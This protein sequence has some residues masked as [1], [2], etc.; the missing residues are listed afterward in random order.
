MSEFITIGEPLVVLCSTQLNKSIADS[1][2]FNRVV[3]GA[4]LNVAIGVSR[5][6]HSAEYISQVGNDPQGEFIQNQINTKKINTQYLRKT[7]KYLTGYQ[8][9]QLVSHGDPKVYNFRKNSAATHINLNFVDK[10]NLSDIKVAHLTG[11]LPAISKEAKESSFYLAQKF[12]LKKIILTFD[13][14]LRPALWKNKTEM[15]KTINAL[16]EYADIVLPGL[17]EGKILTGSDNPEEICDFYLKNRQTKAVFVKVGAKGSY[18]K[19]KEK[20][21]G[22]FVPGFKV[23]KVVDTVGAGDGFALGVITALLEGKNHLQAARRGNA[24][25]AMQV[26]THG[27]NDGYPTRKELAEFYRKME[28]ENYAFI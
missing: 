3:G 8:M 16:A 5:L 18:V 22:T 28:L 6:G 24:I 26:Q 13:P 9:K 14:N 12:N 4:E 25:G 19:L 2:N 10:I 7:N 21:Q 23:K 11:I 17:S 1:T 27:D 15:I 20:K